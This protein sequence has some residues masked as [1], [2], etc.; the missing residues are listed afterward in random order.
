MLVSYVKPIEKN[1]L[2]RVIP[3]NTI[4]HLINLVQIDTPK[5]VKFILIHKH[6]FLIL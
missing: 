6:R 5:Y 3:V 1:T 2:Y 4:N